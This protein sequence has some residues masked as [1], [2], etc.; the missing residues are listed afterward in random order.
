MTKAEWIK[1]RTQEL[2]DMLPQTTLEERNTYTEIR[3]E[4]IEINYSFFGYVAKNQYV[5]D[6][7]AT[8]EDKLQVAL[9]A[10][11]QIWAKYKFSPN[12][13]PD[14]SED[15]EFREDAEYHNGDFVYKDDKLYR[16]KS[17]TPVCGGWNNK[18]WQAQKKYRTDLSFA[19]FFKPRVSEC[20]RR[21]LNTIKYSLRR[22]I[23]MKAAT[24]LGKHWGQITKEDISKVKLTP[25]EMQ[26]LES[27]FNTQYE[28]SFDDA[29]IPSIH[30]SKNAVQQSDFIVSQGI[31]DIYTEEYNSLEDLIMHEMI[32]EQSKLD[33]A[34]L[35]KMAQM[36]GIP[37]SDL[38]KARPRGE[39]KLRTL[40]EE[41]IDIKDSFESGNDFEDNPDI[42]D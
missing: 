12:G 39:E 1:A 29:E 9:M 3:D 31:D 41:A 33:D 20:I 19:V 42:D 36:Y 10:F 38:V 6:P 37:F 40:L 14:Y 8:Y 5:T 15:L 7:M 30:K 32:E 35:L 16:C 2:Y 13:Y 11:C 24:Q 25:Q 26:I 28:V 23:C 27:I 21:E 4:I 22:T 34:H 18:Q 17:E